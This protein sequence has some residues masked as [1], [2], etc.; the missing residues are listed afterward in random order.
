MS[1]IF[2]SANA[3]NCSPSS[4][5]EIATVKW[6]YDGDTVKLTDGRKIRII[7]IDTPE[8]PRKNK[9]GEAFAG[10]ATKALREK[11]AANNNQV[12]LQI[13][14]KTVD[15]YHRQLAHL[16]TPDQQNLSEWLLEQGLATTLLIH[17]NFTFA[18][19]YQKAERRA[20]LAKTNIWSQTDFQI[21]TPAQ[22]DKQFTGYVRLKGT[23]HRI[24]H[25][26]RRVT[27]ALDEKI[28]IT[29]KEPELKLFKNL[30]ELAGKTIT[31]SGLLYR[32]K[33]NAYIRL[34]HPSYLEY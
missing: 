22:L 14:K 23:V 29:I 30:D 9:K 16:F 6:V 19:C 8:M 34:L 13:G 7:G 2:V 18:E 4:S 25:R 28:Y 3:S 1:A 5:T 27:L 11:L 15:K 12:R 31:V 32:H 24:K 21:Q 26:K 33:K 20:Q 17:P 10:Q